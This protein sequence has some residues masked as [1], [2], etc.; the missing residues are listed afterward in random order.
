M[1]TSKRVVVVAGIAFSLTAFLVLAVKFYWNPLDPLDS[2]RAVVFGEYV[3]QTRES[4]LQRFGPPSHEGEGYYGKP[5][6]KWTKAHSPAI[7]MTYVRSTGVLYLSFEE[8]DGTWTCF[9]SA[10]MPDGSQF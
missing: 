4:I 10:W 3:G 9:E 5:E 2:G 8:A 6:V 1:L 7:T